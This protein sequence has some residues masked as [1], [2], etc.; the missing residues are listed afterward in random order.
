MPH[1][2]KESVY[3]KDNIVQIN[4]VRS[5]VRKCD[6][7]LYLLRRQNT[8]RDFDTVTEVYLKS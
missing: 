4:K 3:K 6:Y 2:T 8:F 5:Y 1:P 7:L